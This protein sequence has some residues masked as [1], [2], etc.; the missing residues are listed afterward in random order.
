MTIRVKFLVTEART[1]NEIYTD[2]DIESDMTMTKQRKKIHWI[3][4][5]RT[6]EIIRVMKYRTETVTES[7][8]KGRTM[9]MIKKTS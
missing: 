1:D 6:R 3:I 9:T 7:V 2:T 8:T 4:I 5:V